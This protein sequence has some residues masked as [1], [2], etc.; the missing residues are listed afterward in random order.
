MITARGVN[1]ITMR[2]SDVAHLTFKVERGRR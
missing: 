1:H 2:I